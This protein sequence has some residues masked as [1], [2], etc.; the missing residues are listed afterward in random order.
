MEGSV[1]FK[2]FGHPN[3]SATHETTLMITKDDA[4]QAITII[5]E[6]ITH[7]EEQLA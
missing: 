7:I 1:E 6:V 4:Q 2:A 5:D 3:V